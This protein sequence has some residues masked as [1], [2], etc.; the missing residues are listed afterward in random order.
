MASSKF[1]RGATEIHDANIPA[2][3]FALVVISVVFLFPSYGPRLSDLGTEMTMAGI[4]PTLANSDFVN[5][6]FA[7]K[8]V[9]SG[10]ELVLFDPKAYF[11]LLKSNFGADFSPHI[12]SYPPHALLVFL[13]LGW[14]GYKLGMGLFLG[15]TL[16]F[17]A[18]AASRFHIHH[19]EKRYLPVFLAAHLAFVAT[20]LVA[21]QNGF[22]I[23]G[24]LLLFLA[25][26][27]R[28]PVL[29]ALCLA[30]L[31]IKPQLGILIPFMLA[32]ARSWN[33]MAL[34]A[35]FS[36]ALIAA[37]VLAFGIEP[38]RE[39]WFSVL[40][41]QS[42]VFSEWDGVFVKLMPTVFAALRILGSDGEAA[43]LWHLAFALFCLPISLL[44][45]ARAR[46]QVDLGFLLL[47]S[48]FCITPYAFN[49]DMGALV[50]IAAL[51]LV[52]NASTS[53]ALAMHYA[54]LCLMPIWVYLLASVFVPLAPVVLFATLI[55]VGNYKRDEN[56]APAHRISAAT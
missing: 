28:R 53:P 24:L 19:S 39:Y 34:A 29:A 51:F 14:T 38:W 52:R 33:V 56:Q 27:D 20:N 44:A 47:L 7:G 45:M 21:T 6:W 9:L 13:P 10:Q 11:Q 49:Y 46:N 3:T 55:V 32:F 50:T 41:V 17:Y 40:P 18:F 1:L 26:Y 4:G 42:D 16:A 15:L 2:I 22:L 48:T 54:V 25:Y 35:L 37:S 12:W 43:V 36:T 8:L 5:Y 31:T 23:G 30:V